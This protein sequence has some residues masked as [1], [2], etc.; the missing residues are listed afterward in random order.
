M[1]ALI[2]RVGRGGEST[3]REGSL[4]PKSGFSG[5]GREDDLSKEDEGCP[6][7]V[8]VLSWRPVEKCFQQE[9]LGTHLR[10]QDQG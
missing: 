7:S 2:G 6:D 10:D 8:T 3:S 9:G 4:G 5:E 1:S